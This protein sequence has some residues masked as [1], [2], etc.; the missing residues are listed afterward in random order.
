[1]ANTGNSSHPWELDPKDGIV[2]VSLAPL[3][4]QPNPRPLIPKHQVSNL[5]GVAAVH[6]NTLDL[7]QYVARSD[8]A[9]LPCR[10]TKKNLCH[11]QAAL[12]QLLEQQAHT[13]LLGALLL[14]PQQNMS[15]PV[16]SDLTP[17]AG[18]TLPREARQ[19]GS[20]NLKMAPLLAR[21]F[22]SCPHGLSSSAG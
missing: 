5:S 18:D 16:L 20:G 22:Q 7:V 10:A 1:M 8:L 19:D 4:P 6:A 21:A 15:F 14:P 3:E 13:A 11:N 2:L 17:P 12:L 9:S